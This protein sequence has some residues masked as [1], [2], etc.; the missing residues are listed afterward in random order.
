MTLPFTPVIIIGAGRSGTNILRDVIT[1]LDGFTT[2]PCDEINPI[3]RH[4]NVSWPDDALPA[5]RATPEVR[6]YIRRAFQR[7]W[8]RAGR[9]DFVVEKT[10]ANSL[11]VP[12][13]DAV[14]PEARFIHILRD[15]AEVVPSAAKRWRGEM[16]L[17]GLRYILAK[18]R[19]A[20]LSDLPRYGAR[21]VS[22]R[23]GMITGQ[24]NRLRSWGPRL[25]GMSALA[26]CPLEEI[27]AH[28]W[29]AC[30]NAALDDLAMLDPARVLTLRYAELVSDCDAALS[31]ILE[32]LDVDTPVAARA[33]ACSL[34]R[35]PASLTTDD[36]ASKPPL[37][38]RVRAILA[39][40]QRRLGKG[41][42]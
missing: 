27:C 12:F 25:T 17:P 42:A 2:W 30:V 26:D 36:T 8:M 1:A 28:Q 41:V 16:E 18:A 15:G 21:F 20:P 37:S 40:T 24:S 32:Y 4:G 5:S 29:A 7:Q 22:A 14:L 34:I 9:P 13:V 38:D 11:R 6:T 19:F 35:A 3:W 10:C 23:F 39:P 33:G 31:R